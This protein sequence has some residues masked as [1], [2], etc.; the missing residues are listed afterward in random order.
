MEYA[1]NLFTDGL[2]TDVHPLTTKNNIL[3]DALNATFRTYNGNEL[4]L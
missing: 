1:A 4:L 2:N 3:T